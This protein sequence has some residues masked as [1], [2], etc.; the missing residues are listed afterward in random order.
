[1][2][3]V[4][5]KKRDIAA[6]L[7][8]VTNACEWNLFLNVPSDFVDMYTPVSSLWQRS[9]AKKQYGNLTSEEHDKCHYHSPQ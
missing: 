3:T 8:F 5:C 7:P 1:M 4:V 9:H 6:V 2:C